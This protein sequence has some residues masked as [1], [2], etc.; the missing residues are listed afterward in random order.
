MTKHFDTTLPHRSLPS[1]DAK[2]SAHDAVACMRTFDAPALVVLDG[3]RPLGVVTVDS[4]AQS[5][6]EGGF[7]PALTPLSELMP[8]L[9]GASS[10]NTRVRHVGPAL[11]KVA[12]ANQ[13][14]PRI[15]NPAWTST[16][17]VEA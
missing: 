11:A 13:N 1:I 5:V 15:E 17:W 4:L 16:T 2:A 10:M 9:D 8:A 12:P 14:D 7:D 6:R 3:D